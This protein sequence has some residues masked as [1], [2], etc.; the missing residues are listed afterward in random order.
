MARH[1]IPTAKFETFTSSQYEQA[2]TYLRSAPYPRFV[3]KA[4][5]LAAGKGVLLPETL[6]EA[7]NALKSV[8]LD[9]EFGDAGSE[10]VIEEYL[11]G[12][13]LS[14]LAFC[15]GY[16]IKPLPGA[17]DHKR[18]GEGDTGLNTGG[19]GAYAPAPVGTEAIMTKCMEECLE[20]TMRGMR[21][22]GHAFVGLLFTGFILTADG[23][24][25][26]EY[27]V[28]FGDP[29]TEALM[30]L[31][32]DKVDLAEVM[33]ACVERRLD[34]VE[35]SYKEG[36]AISVILASKGYPG[37]YPKGVEITFGQ[38]PEGELAES[39]CDNRLIA[40]LHRQAFTFSTPVP[41]PLMARSSP[42]EA[43]SSQ[44]LPLG[45]RFGKLL[46]LPTRASMPSTSTARPTGGI[47]PTGHLGRPLPLSQPTDSPTLPPVSLSTTAIPSS[48]PSNLSLKQPA[49]LAPM[50]SSADSVELST[51]KPS[52]WWIPSWSAVLM[53]WEPSCESHWTARSTTR[54][55]STSS[56]CPSTTS[57]CKA[58]S[59]CTFSTT[60]RVPSWTFQ[61]LQMS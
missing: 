53:V 43:V 17:Q 41:R 23:P 6:Q 4:S 59:R 18:I 14:I 60:S 31:L 55:V 11:E 48:R 39:A 44:S 20:P 26:L 56:Q 61:S 52:A 19:M 38:M 42:M 29:E 10:I 51:S 46:T 47:L 33:L 12:P 36:Y 54:S 15:D 27:N 24:K 22:D 3:L 8:L 50:V 28:R 2:L 16:T 45:T 1:F 34:S 37:N 49:D 25:V 30:L 35:L 32:S 40:Y 5:G 7:E 57:S 21:K 58:Q 9:R 13:E